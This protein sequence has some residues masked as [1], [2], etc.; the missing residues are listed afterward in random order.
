MKVNANAKNFSSSTIVQL[1]G[2]TVPLGAAT[3]VKTQQL[4]EDMLV[5]YE[6]ISELTGLDMDTLDKLFQNREYVDIIQNENVPVS[7]L[8]QVVVKK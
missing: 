5:W 4:L 6:F 1:V 8:E 7:I 3:V 2:K